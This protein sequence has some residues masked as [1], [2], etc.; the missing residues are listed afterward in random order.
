MDSEQIW[1]AA[2]LI[3]L[4]RGLDAV[5]AGAVADEAQAEWALRYG[6]QF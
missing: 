1:S 2:F 5:E 4:A 6:E 3:A